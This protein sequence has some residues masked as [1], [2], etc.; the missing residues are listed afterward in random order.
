MK[1][2]LLTITQAVITLKDPKSLRGYDYA[3]VNFYNDSIESLAMID[4]MEHVEQAY[5]QDLRKV[6]FV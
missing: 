1:A 2:L 3:F 4:I 6:A 5:T